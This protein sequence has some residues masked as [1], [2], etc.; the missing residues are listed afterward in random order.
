MWVVAD[1]AEEPV[2]DNRDLRDAPDE[3]LDLWDSGQRTVRVHPV[4][5]VYAVRWLDDQGPV[6]VVRKRPGTDL[7]ES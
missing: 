7:N 4:D 5:S 1:G 3:I 2:G 6:E